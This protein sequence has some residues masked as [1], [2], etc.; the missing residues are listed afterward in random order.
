MDD[1]EDVAI[2]DFNRQPGA[3]VDSAASKLGAEANPAPPEHLE[4]WRLAGFA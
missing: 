3:K 1:P 2:E 4:P